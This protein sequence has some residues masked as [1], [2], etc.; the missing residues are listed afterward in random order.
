MFTDIHIICPLLQCQC[1]VV[2]KSI[3]LEFRSHRF[4]S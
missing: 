3:W 1:L 4:E 2:Q